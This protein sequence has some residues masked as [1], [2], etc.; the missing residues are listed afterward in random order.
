M[1]GLGRPGQDDLAVLL[2]Y[3]VRERAPLLLGPPHAHPEGAAAT[4]PV[5]QAERVIHGVSDSAACPG[6]AAQE[7]VAVEQVQRL[8]NLVLLLKDQAVQA[9]AGD[10][11]QHVPG[12]EDLLVGSPDLRAGGGA[13]PGGGDGLDGVHVPLAAA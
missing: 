11:V 8:G 1:P 7:H 4:G 12:I 10:L 3:P 9:A 13:D 6:Q 5:G 2:H